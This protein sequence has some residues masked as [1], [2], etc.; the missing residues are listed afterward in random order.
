[1][2]QRKQ[3]ER[4]PGYTG[5]T[6]QLLA[7]YY[8]QL[9]K[10][11]LVLTRGDEG[12]AEE[13]VQDFCLYFTL[14]KPDLSA[15]ENLDGYLYTSLRHIYLSSL[16]RASREAMRF[17]SVAEFDSFEFAIASDQSEDPLQIQNDL[18]RICGYTVWRK[19]SSKSA[20]YF[21]LHFFHGYSR[22][23]T[24]ELARLPISA[25][26]NK[27]KIARSEIKSYL[28]DSG[29]MRLVNRSLPPEASLGWSL[30]S[31]PEL[32]RELRSTIFDA[33]HSECLPEQELLAEYQSRM[34]QP[35]ECSLLAHVVSCARCL[36]L[37]DRHFRRPTLEDR[38][39]LDGIDSAGIASDRAAAGSGGMDYRMILRSNHR[40]W[41]LVHEHRPEILSIAVDGK[42]IA[43]H[44]IRGRDNILS[45]RVD[46]PER[47][48]FV[49]VFSEQDLRLALLPVDD[50]P[51]EGMHVRTQH[52]ALSDS[53]WLELS[54]IFDGMGLS[55][56]VTYHDPAIATGLFEEE[57]EVPV[58]RL[59]QAEHS[60]FSQESL[61]RIA[62]GFSR[63][64]RPV[65][66]SSAMAWA[67]LLLV[68]VGVGGYLTYRHTVVPLTANEVLSRATKAES[69][70]LAGRTEHQT[71][72]FEEVASDGRVLSQGVVDLWKDGD[73]S[74]YLRR[75]YDS[76]HGLIAARWRIRSAEHTSDRSRMLKGRIGAHPVDSINSLWDQDFSAH[77]F[78][79]LNKE[80]QIQATET[81]YE[82]E[83]HGPVEGHPQLISATLVLDRSLNPVRETMRVQAGSDIHVLR[84]VRTSY[85][86]KPS[87]SVPDTIFDPKHELHS[88][89]DSH[90]LLERGL[91]P[92]TTENNVQLARLQ[93]AVLYRLNNLGSDTG[94]PI[95]VVRSREGRIRVSGTV[96]DALLRQQII[97]DLEKLEDHRLLEIQLIPQHPTGISGIDGV[98]P[99]ETKTF[100]IADG[101]PPA[102]L[103]LRRHFEST[104]VSGNQMDSAI[105]GYSR[106]ALL[107]AQRALQHAY[108]LNRLGTSL[109]ADEL[110]S[111]GTSSQQ[112]WTE[113]VQSHANEV[114]NHLRALR[115]QLKEVAPTDNDSPEAE[116][117]SLA[118]ENPEGFKRAVVQLLRRA[119]DLNRDAGRLFTSNGSTE[120]QRSS[121]PSLQN[122]ID[123]IPLQQAL[124]IERFAVLLNRSERS[125]VNNRE[126]SGKS[127]GNPE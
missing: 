78:S 15:V 110:N 4:T 114:E 102:D 35:V 53:R 67:L 117:H 124:E 121:N 112:Q 108:A 23:E 101:R 28:K 27:L 13:I 65:V 51:P 111:I 79:V 12:K 104:G 82:L 71:L 58:V 16:A 91:Q 73:G 21:I 17:L 22:R 122:L 119:Q 49:E 57:N 31:A 77:A 24:A 18:R 84:F 89:N 98:R 74:R 69:A 105:A 39:P 85:E 76:E 125:T 14:T 118:I 20:S 38:E 123:A 120:R 56:Q 94:E 2:E 88:S 48:Q 63:F 107:H 37:I 7:S 8:S 68:V 54:L 87:T 30:R 61:S 64:F 43:F 34:P 59:P 11:G 1:M 116:A 26:Y 29:R 33:R 50:L 90:S 41:G 92:S 9:L 115:K 96:G 52:V 80:V 3:R 10:W 109:S 106:E 19:E 70:A 127:K 100:E 5:A 66:P 45:A 97:S 113:M 44:E 72:Q 75:F 99:Q 103:I 42:I 47:V 40:R 46:R 95:E 32:F 25:I 83:T 60:A 81:G 126:Y 6:E 36:T 55:S 62:A 93:V 86:R